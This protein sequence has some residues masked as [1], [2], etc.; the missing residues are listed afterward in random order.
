MPPTVGNH[1]SVRPERGLWRNHLLRGQSVVAVLNLDQKPRRRR[2]RSSSTQ[3]F[4]TGQPRPAT[5]AVRGAAASSC[6]RSPSYNGSTTAPTNAGTYALQVQYAGSA[7]YTPV[8]ANGSFVV[9]KATPIIGTLNDI[10]GT[11]NGEPW[12]ATST[13][14]A[15]PASG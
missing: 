11:Y 12:G 1:P 5:V 7:N 8:T 15:L 6:F 9:R 13:S 4:Y 3:P 10:T 14:P 2:S